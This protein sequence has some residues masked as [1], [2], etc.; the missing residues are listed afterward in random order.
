MRAQR[1]GRSVL[2]G[3]KVARHQV[4]RVQEARVRLLVSTWGRHYPVEERREMEVEV[5]PSL[6]LQENLKPVD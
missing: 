2:E 5:D 1:V 4:D 3:G 6:V